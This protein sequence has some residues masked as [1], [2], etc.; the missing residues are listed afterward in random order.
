M[1]VFKGRGLLAIRFL[2]DKKRGGACA[3]L[4]LSMKL[5]LVQFLELEFKRE[6][7]VAL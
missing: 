5:T 6:L 4:L 2:C 7:E 1:T 3:R